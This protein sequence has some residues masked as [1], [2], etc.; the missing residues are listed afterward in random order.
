MNLPDWIQLW[1]ASRSSLVDLVASSRVQAFLAMSYSLSSFGRCW[2]SLISLQSLAHTEA[3]LS[4][5]TNCVSVRPVLVLL[6]EYVSPFS[7]SRPFGVEGFQ[8]DVMR[9]EP[10]SL[11]LVCHATMNLLCRT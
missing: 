2:L 5:R 7:V 8:L 11:D 1:N 4:V 6:F 10:E 3:R 9:A